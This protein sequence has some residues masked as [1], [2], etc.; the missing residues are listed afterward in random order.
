[1][2]V[3]GGGWLS[4]EVV[5]RKKNLANAPRMWNGLNEVRVWGKTIRQKKVW[6]SRKNQGATK[7]GEAKGKGRTPTQARHVL[8]DC[9]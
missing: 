8:L 4:E 1:M 7:Q 2:G 9:G 5:K 6:L 3:L